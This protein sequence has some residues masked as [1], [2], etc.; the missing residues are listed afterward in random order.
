[1]KIITRQGILRTELF[2]EIVYHEKVCCISFCYVYHYEEDGEYA[3]E[4]Q[5]QVPMTF[6]NYREARRAFRKYLRARNTSQESV[7]FL[8]FRCPWPKSVY[9]KIMSHKRESL[10]FL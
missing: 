1:M 4:F 10:L 2:K 8:E 9:R 3:T 6:R 7:S 5:V